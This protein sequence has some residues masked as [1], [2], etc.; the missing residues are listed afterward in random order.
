MPQST[1]ILNT[2]LT[3]C[4][5]FCTNL[6]QINETVQKYHHP[7]E[8]GNQCAADSIRE[9]TVRGN[10]ACERNAKASGN[11]SRGRGDDFSEWIV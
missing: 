2:L 3:E 10:V 1:I 7:R 9:E 4:V 5:R 6:L 8:T 11:L